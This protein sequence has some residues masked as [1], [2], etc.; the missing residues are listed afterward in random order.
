M[1]INLS[2]STDG[3]IKISTG[4]ER[5]RIENVE[6]FLARNRDAVLVQLEGKHDLS[7]EYKPGHVCRIENGDDKYNVFVGR[8]IIGQLPPEAISFA[9]S[10]DSSPEY[11]IAMVGKVEHNNDTDTD[12]ISIYIAE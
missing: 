11:L 9:E 4:S 6:K 7:M 10:V 2:I 1:N 12:K 8:H 3:A 5:V